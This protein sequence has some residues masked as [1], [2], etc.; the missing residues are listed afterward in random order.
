MKKILVDF[1][2]DY[3]VKLYISIYVHRLLRQFWSDFENNFILKSTRG[4]LRLLW[5]DFVDSLVIFE[6]LGYN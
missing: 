6:G 3:N 5:N 4:Y 2:G 1:E